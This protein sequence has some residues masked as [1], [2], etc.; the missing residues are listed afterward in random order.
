MLHRLPTRQRKA[1]RL[2]RRRAVPERTDHVRELDRR[3]KAEETKRK[4]DGR[5]QQRHYP[6]WLNDD[7]AAE[8]VADAR[9]IDYPSAAVIADLRRID[10]LDRTISNKA[11]REAVGRLAAAT[12]R[13]FKAVLEKKSHA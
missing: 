12:Y 10:S 4:R 11:Y 2:T 1:Q 6:F 9:R 5:Y 3:R 13:H 8:V 7:E